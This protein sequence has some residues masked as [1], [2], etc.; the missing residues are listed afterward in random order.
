VIVFVSSVVII[1]AAPPLPPLETGGGGGGVVVVVE[2]VDVDA[3]AVMF[4]SPVCCSPVVM[5][6][7]VSASG[8]ARTMD[9]SRINV[10]NATKNL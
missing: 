5:L 8:A 2:E 10:I 9:G 1:V 6:P 4:T 3:L 7:V